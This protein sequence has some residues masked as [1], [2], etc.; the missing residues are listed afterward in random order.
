MKKTY[1]ESLKVP[2]KIYYAN[3]IDNLSSAVSSVIASSEATGY[4]IDYIRDNSP[5]TKWR[6][7]GI[8]E[9]TI[10]ITFIS[11]VTI[12]AVAW[13]GSNI[14]STDT[15]FK[16]EAGT[17]S[18]CSDISLDLTKTGKGVVILNSLIGWTYQYF[19]ITIIKTTG[20]YIELGLLGLMGDFYEFEKNY[21]WNF[22]T[23]H[24][25]E[26]TT[27]KS[28]YGLIKRKKR[29]SVKIFNFTFEFLARTQAILFDEII[30]DENYIWYYSEDYSDIYFGIVD[31]GV[32][33]SMQNKNYYSIS[34]SFTEAL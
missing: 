5:A 15:T 4:E 32:L 20:T 21:N 2:D 7:T 23:G 31:L 14:V 9:E 16:I 13:A 18:A 25:T 30:R 12:K 11:A 19:K 3:K 6:S 28:K 17:T 26:F 27:N 8:T 33:E 22:S 34:M 1:E 10:L 29:Y 24:L